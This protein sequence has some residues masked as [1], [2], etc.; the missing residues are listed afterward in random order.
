MVLGLLICG[1]SIG[2]AI[3]DNDFSNSIKMLANENAEGEIIN[4]FVERAVAGDV[5]GAMTLLTPAIHGR[6]AIVERDFKKRVFPFFK[7]YKKMHNAKTVGSSVFSDGSR[8]TTHY[9][10]MVTNTEVKSPFM[11]SFRIE[12]DQPYIISIEIN[13]CV[14]NRHPSCDSYEEESW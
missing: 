6:E 3:A 7:N 14:A 13:K 2:N 8:G 12:D 4:Q 11:V 9:V 10:Y 1:L 5:A